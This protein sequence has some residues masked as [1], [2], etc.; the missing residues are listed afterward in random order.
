MT[1]ALAGFNEHGGDPIGHRQP[2]Q[3]FRCSGA[4]GDISRVKKLVV[5][6]KAGGHPERRRRGE[7][8][9][10][11][12][13]CAGR[14]PAIPGPW[15]TWRTWWTSPCPSSPGVTGGH[16]AAPRARRPEGFRRVDFILAGYVPDSPPPPHFQMV[17]LGSEENELPLKKDRD[18]FNVVVMP[19]NLGMEMRLFQG[20]Q[21]GADLIGSPEPEQTLSWNE[22]PRSKKRWARPTTLPPSPPA[23]TG[24]PGR[25]RSSPEWRRLRT[26]A[27]H[28]ANDRCAL[29]GAPMKGATQSQAGSLCH[30]RPY[31]II[32]IIE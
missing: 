24:R 13:P 8:A 15:T 9:P 5:P 25:G 19:R 7:P 3:P 10:V 16:L 27:N 29:A 12:R 1:Q 21:P 17:L 2:G 32:L 22:W 11:L 30:C 26:A 28:L 4:D 20:P 6:G 23:A 18:R 14:S 31:V